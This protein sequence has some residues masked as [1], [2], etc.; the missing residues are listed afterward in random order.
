MKRR[1]FTL[2]SFITLSLLSCGES[3]KPVAETD[4]AT[5]TAEGETPK[6]IMKTS[7]GDITLEL[8]PE[9]APISV[10]N[11]LSYVDDGYYDGTV[12]HRVISDFMIQGGGF[13]DGGDT[14]E[15]KDTK[16]PIKNESSNGL[17]N[18]KGTIAMART[19]V[20]DSATSQFYINV[21]HNAMLDGGY[22]VFGKVIDGYDV[23][24]KIENVKTN[25]G[26]LDGRPAGDVPVE[27]VTITSV[28][29][30]D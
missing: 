15:K 12:F 30:Q 5:V 25:R 9:K 8:Y 3:T 7:E 27:T 23:V 21:K 29:R 28:K 2:L 11:F 4:K 14:L 10:K 24:E 22:A 1:T 20:M 19:Q 17:K 26:R 16:A 13:T 6:V 18:E